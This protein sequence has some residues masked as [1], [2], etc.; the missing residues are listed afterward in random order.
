MS[1]T[2]EALEHIEAN[3]IAAGQ[4]I[5][6]ELPDN[7]T[8]LPCT[9]SI[10]DLQKYAPNRR[11]FSGTLLTRDIS[12]YIS[13]LKSTPPESKPVGF[14]NADNL[15]CKSFLNLGDVTAPGHGDWTA[16]LAMHPTAPYAALLAVSGKK[17]D[18]KG[19]VNWLEDWAEYLTPFS[20]DE[21]VEYYGSLH[22]ATGAIRHITIK[23][24][25]EGESKVNDFDVE[26]S[27]MERIEASSRQELPGGFEFFCEPYLGL[28]A[29]RFVLRLQ[30]LTGGDEPALT[31]RV[32]ALE[33]TKEEIV[34]D[35]KR[36]LRDGLEGTVN[37][38]IGEFTP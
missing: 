7:A 19:L 21:G 18:Q 20:K 23:A 33:A 2:K 10:V 31:L 17:F 25:R 32:S 24:L 11:R 37:L 28:P 4:T 9:F 26:R 14:I 15:S 29:R 36:L 16:T 38:T 13:Y 35:F 5:Q 34:K 3:A 6:V 8:A 27:A 1:I 22:K 12:D 30:V